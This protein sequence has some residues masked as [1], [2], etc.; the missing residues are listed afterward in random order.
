[1]ALEQDS[2]RASQRASTPTQPI[3][4]PAPQVLLIR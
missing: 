3:C 1:M 4:Q 2:G